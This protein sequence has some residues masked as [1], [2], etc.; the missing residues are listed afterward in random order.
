MSNDILN[1]KSTNELKQEIDKLVRED[2]RSLPH[3]AKVFSAIAKLQKFDVLPETGSIDAV[4]AAIAAGNTELNRGMSSTKGIPSVF[5][6]RELIMGAMYPGTL[7]AL[8]NGMYFAAPSE[9]REDFPGFP[10][11][12]VVARKYIKGDGS[13]ILVR[14]ALN[15]SAKVADC[16]DIKQDLKENKNRAKLAGITDIGA[17]AAS[18]GIDAFYSDNVYM[19]TPERVYVVLNRGVILIQISCILVQT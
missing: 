3:K 6:A 5:Y 9:K 10:L 18:L 17:F 16:H 13:G 11:V 12:S 19:D 2:Q 4:N 1:G 14:A 7:S 15:K 8:G